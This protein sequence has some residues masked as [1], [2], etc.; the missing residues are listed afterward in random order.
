RVVLANRQCPFGAYVEGRPSLCMM[1]SNVFG[2]IAASNLGYANVE[3]EKSI[4][5]GHSGCRVVVNF[6]QPDTPPRGREYFGEQ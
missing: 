1:T 6:L 2:T 5:R 4:A 3:I